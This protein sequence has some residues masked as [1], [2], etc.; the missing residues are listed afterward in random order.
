VINRLTSKPEAV[1]RAK[2]LFVFFHE[3]ESQFGDLAQIVKLEKR[4]SDL[5][6][7]D[8]Q[9]ARFASRFTTEASKFDPTSVRPIISYKS[10]MKPANL[11]SVVPTIEEPAVAPPPQL[12][13]PQAPPAI[14]SPRVNP[15]LLP[16]SNSPKRPFDD[17]DN[18]LDQ[19]R[20]M[21]RG[22]S[23]LK[24]AAGRRL[25]AARRNMARPGE[26]T[27]NAS[28]APPPA[29]LPQGINFLL[30]II[31]GAQHYR[32]MSFFNP[33]KLTNVLRGVDLNRADVPGA[34]ARQQQYQQQHT[35][36]QQQV[37]APTPVQAPQYGQPPPQINQWG[38]PPPGGIG[39]TS[40]SLIFQY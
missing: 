4:M 40:A 21:V 26:G 28:V 38:P 16:I 25:D 8:P 14:N 11:P 6:P 19:P 36:Q 7:E 24:G 34:I 18:E 33:E 30:G 5:F 23:P 31:P 3:F 13:Q 32:D 37:Q 20:K 29:R 22:E 1:P 17:V 2:S 10:Q 27:P 15:A 39:G 35:A 12:Q 9:L